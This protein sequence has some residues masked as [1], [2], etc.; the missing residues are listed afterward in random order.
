M[1]NIQKYWGSE[2]VE[3]KAQADAW[4]DSSDFIKLGV[5]SNMIRIAPPAMGEKLALQP[6]ATH[7]IQVP[8]QEKKAIFNCPRIMAKQRCRACDMVDRLNS[9]GVA[10]DQARAREMKANKNFIG[11]AVNRK[12]PEQGLRKVR[13]S[14]TLYDKI[15]ELHEIIGGGAPNHDPMN[16]YDLQIIRKGEGKDTEWNVREGKTG[17]LGTG[18]E[19]EEWGENMPSLAADL[20]VPT[21]EQIDEMLGMSS[22]ASRGTAAASVMGGGRRST[23]TAQDDV[24]EP[25][26]T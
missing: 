18:P 24:E 21:S 4:T 15:K 1:S 23:R 10:V 6:V 12:A 25:E 16:G 5:G 2:D 9:S 13:I 26:G 19:M 14:P 8:G 3:A 7:Y 17:P 20:R 22:A 11:R